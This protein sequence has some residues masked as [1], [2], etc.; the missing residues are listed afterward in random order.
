MK[1]FGE[2]M[3]GL[4]AIL[5]MLSMV[6]AAAAFVLWIFY[7]LGWGTGWFLNLVVGPEMVFGMTFEQFIGLVYVVVGIA[8]SGKTV[9]NKNVEKKIEDRIDK[10]VND[11][12]KQYRGY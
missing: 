9:M 7:G 1:K 12:K 4:G 5:L 3:L 6:L 2:V 10:V 8:V 11:V